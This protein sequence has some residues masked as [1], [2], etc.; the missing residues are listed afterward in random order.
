VD[1]WKVGGQEGVS[2]LIDR[3][4]NAPKLAISLQTDKGPEDQRCGPGNW[5]DGRRVVP[6]N[7]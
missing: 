4:G 7:E 2:L 5:L 3:G 6:G 1:V